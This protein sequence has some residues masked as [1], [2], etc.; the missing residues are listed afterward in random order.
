M[1][2][3]DSEAVLVIRPTGIE[4]VYR[5]V[6]DTTYVL[7]Q[8]VERWWERTETMVVTEKEKR[9]GAKVTIESVLYSGENQRMV[10][11]AES[12]TM[13]YDDVRASARDFGRSLAKS[14]EKDGLIAKD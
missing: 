1:E 9:V 10:W 5:A 2:K 13:H 8:H 7:Q 4:D 6:P 3:T 12:T 14:L 11:K